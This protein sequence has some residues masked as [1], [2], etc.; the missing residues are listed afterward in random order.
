MTAHDALS[1]RHAL[2]IDE[3]GYGT[4]LQDRGRVGF[5]HL[6]VPH[7]GPVDRSSAALA[8]RLVGN[9]DGTTVIETLGGLVV[10]TRRAAV[11]ATPELGR[12]VLS[13]G[14]SLRVAPGPGRRW[15]H[16]AV[17]GGVVVP[18]VLGSMSHDTLSGLGPPALHVG[19]ELSIGADPRTD[20]PADFAPI[21]LG[22]VGPVGLWPGPTSDRDRTDPAGVTG[23][24]TVT[25]EVS[26]V[27][28]RLRPR[29]PSAGRPSTSSA[30]SPRRPSGGLVIGA[31]QLT[32]SGELIV[33][34]ADHPTTGGYPV[35]GVVDRP[36][37]DRLAQAPVGGEIE[38][39]R[40]DPAPLDLGDPVAG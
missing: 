7:A 18:T 5:A 8:N 10:T 6:G 1:S 19:S 20:M 37:V 24:W 3:L 26:R 17:R 12:R 16:L 40:I 39:R 38:V 2:R 11:V 4:T 34:L 33:M 25:H 13:A 36:D 31:V 21:A 22:H 27:G 35:I 23:P 32:P 28:L 15:T 30:L 29:E 14:E 9:D